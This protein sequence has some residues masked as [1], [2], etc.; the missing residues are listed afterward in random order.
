MNVRKAKHGTLLT[1][2]FS[3]LSIA[4]VY[5][6]ALVLI[7]SFKKKAY[8]SRASFAIPADKMYVGFDNYLNGIEK[9][10][11]I[12][13]F[14]WSLFITVFSVMAIVLCTSM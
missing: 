13:A 7:N 9:T 8:I 10:G 1:I 11:F 14:G 2:F 6:I 4:Y 3:V 5:P 12:Q